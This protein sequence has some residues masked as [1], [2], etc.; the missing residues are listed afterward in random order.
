MDV[1]SSV[2]ERQS[3]LDQIHTAALRLEPDA[4]LTLA[5]D[6]AERIVAMH[7][8]LGMS[9]FQV[10][11]E[12]VRSALAEDN[13]RRALSRLEGNPWPASSVRINSHSKETLMDKDRIQ[14]SAKQAKGA[15]KEVVGKVT[16]DAKLQAD[17][18]ADKTEGKIQNAVG[19]VKDAL[20]GK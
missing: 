11:D 2:S 5:C 15:I 12:I 3:V 7:P 14:G 6:Y 13:K 9:E 4:L 1:H 18:K 19:G 20:R 16:G 8:D 17:G 10:I